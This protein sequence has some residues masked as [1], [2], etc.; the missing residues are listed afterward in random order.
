MTSFVRIALA[1]AGTFVEVDIVEGDTVSRLAKRAC[2]ELSHWRVNAAQIALY[3]VAAGGDDLP[4]PS[5]V[6]SARHL[7]Q[8]GWSLVRAGISSGAWLVAR[9]LVDEGASGSCRAS[10][11]PG[12]LPSLVPLTPPN[13]TGAREEEQRRAREEEQRRAREEEQLRLQREQTALLSEVLAAQRM[14]PLPTSPAQL[15]HVSLE[16]LRASG[17]VI[18]ASPTE[19]TPVLTAAQQAALQTVGEHDGE[20]GVVKFLTPVLARLRLVAGAGGGGDADP[21][22][23]A[24]VNSERFQWLA[25]PAAAAR[26][27]LR[28]KP[29][30]FF[31]WLPFV[32]LRGGAD[33]QGGAA[34]GF[35]FGALAG[36]ALQRERCAPELYEAKRGRLSDGDFG[37][38]VA[39]HRCVPGRCRGLLFG[40]EE[41]WAYESAHGLPVR[42]TKDRWAAG[43]AE[44]RLRAFLSAASAEP[45]LVALLRRLLLDLSAA[46]LHVAGRCYLGSG[47]F[48]HVFTVSLP[49]HDA[50]HAL[51]AV[52]RTEPAPFSAEFARMCALA[53]RGAPIVAPVPGS[54][55]LY[56]ADSGG[57]EGGGFSGGY[58]MQRVGAPHAVGELRRL[59]A[60]FGALRALH[61]FDAV[62]GDARLPNLLDMG[63]EELA[64]IDL[65]TAA[66]ASGEGLAA[67]KRHDAHTLARS[68]LGLA[69]GAPLPAAVGAALAGWGED[70]CGVEEAARAVWVARG[71]AAAA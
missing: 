66:P 62:H 36:P 31:S 57:G 29:D 10:A 3:L 9:K 22:R 16:A 59:T 33:G 32:A 6:D 60:A 53:A 37:E 40:A 39:Y 54:L 58:L 1:G 25:P 26:A 52:L 2:A 68:A 49:G 18:V 70:G 4:A 21:C 35:Y 23:P 51:K 55:R 46:P 67:L 27:D 44:G 12:T 63:S 30:L 50:P 38:L 17:N 41:F 61:S 64:W 13:L 69:G 28:F 7:D 19:G 24:L 14:A 20:A 47:A 11:F 45:P 43:G 65:R 56:E 42:L 8:I 5:A 34:D 71:R 15:A 48:G